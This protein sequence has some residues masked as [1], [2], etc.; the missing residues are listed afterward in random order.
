MAKADIPP[1]MNPYVIGRQ[2]SSDGGGTWADLL[3]LNDTGYLQNTV[4]FGP[5]I[6]SKTVFTPGRAGEAP[7]VNPGTGEQYFS[8]GRMVTLF[9]SNNGRE[10]IPQGPDLLPTIF[11]DTLT[12]NTSTDAPGNVEKA[13]ANQTIV[14]GVNNFTFTV[15][16]ADGLTT[17]DNI[18]IALQINHNA[19]AD[20]RADLIAPNGATR[21]LF[22]NKNV[23]PNG[24]IQGRGITGQQM[25]NGDKQTIFIDSAFFPIQ[26]GNDTAHP[27]AGCGGP[28]GCPYWPDR[29]VSAASIPSAP[30]RCALRT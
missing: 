18:S 6:H 23:P 29:A 4:E 3:L 26:D 15:T 21:T 13:I 14:D 5:Y 28:R 24:A 9:T 17:V 1:L 22:L 10:Q 12:L 2:Y 8:G 20:L 19:L 27:T 25:G 30:G 7:V 16:A 11:S